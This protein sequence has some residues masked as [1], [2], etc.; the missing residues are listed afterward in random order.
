MQ[1]R[2]YTKYEVYEDGRIFSY[3]TNSFL[4]PKT[5]KGGYQTVRLADDNGKTKLYLVHR[6][7]Y[8]TFSGKPIPL[9]MQ[10]NHIDENKENNSRINLNLMTPKENSN[11]GTGILRAA[12]SR[13]KKVGA[14]KNGKLVMTFQSSVEAGRNGF[15]KGAVSACCRGEQKKHNG[16]E[17]RYIKK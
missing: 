16:F 1:F 5:N 6:V 7:V 11:W 13:S 3:L 4:K 12:K 10:V 2:D 15:N 8:E 9:G 14:F 17:W